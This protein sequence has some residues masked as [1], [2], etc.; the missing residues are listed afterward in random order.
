MKQIDK[1]CLGLFACRRI[2]LIIYHLFIMKKNVFRAPI[3]PDERLA[4]ALR[5][6]AHHSAIILKLEKQLYVEWL[7]KYAK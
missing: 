1:N 6:A 3:P 7:K 5:F 4:I 2:D